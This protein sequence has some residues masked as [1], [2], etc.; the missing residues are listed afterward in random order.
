MVEFWSVGVRKRES[1]V[2][3]QHGK[4]VVGLVFW[5]WKLSAGVL[6]QFVIVGTSLRCLVRLSQDTPFLV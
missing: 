2:V 3:T 1:E 6:D 5:L 4:L